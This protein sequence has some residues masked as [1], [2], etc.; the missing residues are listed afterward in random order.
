MRIVLDW[1]RE[2]VNV[3][4]GVER[5]ASELGLKGFEVASVERDPDV[6]EV[7]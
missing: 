5:I 1:L 2:L 4:G 3:P 7:S 6:I